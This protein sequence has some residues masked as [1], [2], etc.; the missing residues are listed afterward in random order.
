[1]PLLW[2]SVQEGLPEP[3]YDGWATMWFPFVVM[4]CEGH[5]PPFIVGYYDPGVGWCDGAL[6]DEVDG[7]THWL[8]LV[9]PEGIL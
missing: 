5:D 4:F 3:I 1:M 6:G 8:P 7:V 9:R 2:I